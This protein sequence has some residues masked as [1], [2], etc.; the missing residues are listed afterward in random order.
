MTSNSKSDTMTRIAHA[1]EMMLLIRVEYRRLRYWACRCI[2]AVLEGK[3]HCEDS[4][5]N[6]MC[7]VVNKARFQGV[8][9]SQ[10]DRYDDNLPDMLGGEVSQYPGTPSV[11]G[12]HQSP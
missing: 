10:I 8:F 5:V 9:S 4:G 6:N 2:Q 12:H 1:F 7:L 11:H 3:H